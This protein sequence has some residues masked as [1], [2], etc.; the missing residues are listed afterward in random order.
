MKRA[1]YISPNARKSDSAKHGRAATFSIDNLTL[2]E[3]KELL[4]YLSFV[5]QKIKTS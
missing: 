2:D 5:R 1:G 3:E 4:Q